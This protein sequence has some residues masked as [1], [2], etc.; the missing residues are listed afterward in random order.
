MVQLGT[1]K[2]H[3]RWI[4]VVCVDKFHVEVNR[5]KDCDS[6]YVVLES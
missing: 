6:N 1:S 3:S 4:A 5:F 2:A